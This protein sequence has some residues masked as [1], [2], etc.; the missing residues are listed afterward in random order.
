MKISWAEPAREP[1]RALKYRDKV[2]IHVA[3]DLVKVRRCG[4]SNVRAEEMTRKP[5]RIVH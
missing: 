3:E 2:C 1:I 5:A 4:I